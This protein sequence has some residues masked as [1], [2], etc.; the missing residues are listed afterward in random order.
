MVDI[1]T[2]ILPGIDD[3]AR[4]WDDAYEMAARACDSGVDTIVCTHH[5]NIPGYIENYNNRYL[6]NL[7]YEF[8]ARLEEGGFPLTVLR[9]MEIY[10]TPN[11]VNHVNRGEL[12]SLNRTNTCLIEF[13]FDES[14]DFIKDTVMDFLDFGITP[15]VAHPER[16]YCVQEFPEIV[17]D[18][19]RMGGLTQVNKGS[20]LGRFGREEERTSEWMMRHDLVTCIASD[21]HRPNIRTTD[22]SEIWKY[23]VRRYSKDVA[24]RLMDENPRKIVSGRKL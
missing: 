3:G 19:L 18:I 2:H 17:V 9:G 5:A 4:N 20:I 16:Y 23:V 21:A 10:S 14:P 7:F 22:M 15:L 24:W 8:R 1:H 13:G 6:D 11:V 12:L